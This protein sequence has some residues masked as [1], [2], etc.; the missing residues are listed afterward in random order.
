MRDLGYSLGAL[1][2]ALLV[3]GCGSVKNG[4]SDDMS[5]SRQLG[6]SCNT[7]TDC[8]SGFCVDGVCCDSACTGT[9]MA[10][11][12]AGKK[13]TCTPVP[14]DTDPK[15]QCKAN[16]SMATLNPDGGIMIPDAGLNQVG[17][18][19]AGSC[20]GAGACKFPDKAK[21]CGDAFCNDTAT[22]AGYMCDGMGGCQ[23]QELTCSAYSC[24]SG[25]C[26]TS[27]SSQNDCQ[28]T[29]YCDGASS[30]C[31]PKK[32][33]GVS[34]VGPSEC[35][36]GFCYG[37][38]QPGTQRVCCNSDCGAIPGGNCNANATNAGKCQCVVMGTP[39]SSSCSI[40]Y[41]DVD[42]D[43]YGDKND[44]NGT[45]GCD[46]NPPSAKVKNDHTDCDDSKKGAHPGPRTVP[47]DKPFY[48]AT[49]GPIANGTYDY[50]CDGVESHEY[51]EF[52]GNSNGSCGLCAAPSG[53][54]CGTPQN[55]CGTTTYET[56]IACP[57]NT[58]YN[59][60]TMTSSPCCGCSGFFKIFCLPGTECHAP[61]YYGYTAT[62]NCG[63]GATLHSCS[64]C[65]G[66]SPTENA[67]FPHY[68]YQ[69]CI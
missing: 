37:D 34:C 4:G 61:F 51:P 66:G 2:L 12:V 41:R 7:L 30:T 18:A 43:G 31:K 21:S 23:V 32:D 24:V 1:C 67:T 8:A 60:I 28:S 65:S 39:C 5:I 19:C 33:L 49:D 62:V 38:G 26:K 9:C 6:E 44:T 68:A 63:Q 57:Y 11:D 3:A 15:M 52:P 14:A 58:S 29:H 45:V 36:S 47:G 10:C 16:M 50:N 69:G 46:S 42:G 59:P 20:N 22:V 48:T 55:T 40:Y 27:C 25:A 53:V 13:G 56:Q 35:N 17:N 64:Y 54:I